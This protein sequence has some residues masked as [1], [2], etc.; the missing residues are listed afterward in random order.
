MQYLEETESDIDLVNQLSPKKRNELK[1]YWSYTE[2]EIGSVMSPTASSN[3]AFSM[4][5]TDA[6]KKLTGVAGDTEYISI[7]YVVDRQ[8]LVGYLF[9]KQ[10]IIA[11]ANQTIGEIMET[12][13]ISADP[14]ASKETV[15]RDMLDYGN[16]SLPIVDEEGKIVGIVTYDDLMDVIDEIKTERLRPLRGRR[17]GRNPGGGEIGQACRS[18]SRLPWLMVLLALSMVSSVVLSLFGGAFSG[19]DGAKACSPPASPSIC[20]C[21]LDMSGNSGTQSLAVMIRYLTVHDNVLTE[22]TDQETPAPRDRHRRDPGTR[23]RR[24]RLRRLARLRPRH[25]RLAART[26]RPRDGRRHGRRD[27]RRAHDRDRPRRLHPAPHE[28]AQEGP[29][30]RLG[31]VHHDD[32][33]HRHACHLLYPQSRDPAAAV[34]G[35]L[36]KDHR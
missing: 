10:L 4:K 19:S 32:R 23:H 24:H 27:R 7:L 13:I 5:V 18:K 36:R 6:M 25:L 2:H 28:L 3:S 16:S 12:R 26:A 15:A 21:S 11:R 31:T 8:K 33:R 29:G 17:P 30:R 9:L 22:G 34:R 20:P 14:H 1:K 35:Q